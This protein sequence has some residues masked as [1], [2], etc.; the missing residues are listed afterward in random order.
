MRGGAGGRSWDRN[1]TFHNSRPSSPES[2]FPCGPISLMGPPT[3]AW[4]PLW[5][6]LPAPAPPPQPGNHQALL[7]ISEPFQPPPDPGSVASVCVQRKP[8]G[9]GST[10]GAPVKVTQ[11]S[12]RVEPGTGRPLTRLPAPG[13]TSTCPVCLLISSVPPLVSPAPL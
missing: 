1:G 12:P 11:I 13:W 10:R 8:D 6:L 5:G 4:K 7:R 9:A 3:S 2:V